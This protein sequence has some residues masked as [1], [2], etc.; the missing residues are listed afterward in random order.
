MPD[1]NEYYVHR[2]GR[3]GRAKRRGVAYTLVS[4]YPA[5]IRLNDIAKFTKN[6]VSVVRFDEN[7]ELVEVEGK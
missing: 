3:T 7:G 6:T 5:M 1:E 2:I 4:D